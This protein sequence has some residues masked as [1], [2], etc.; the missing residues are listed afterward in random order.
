MWLVG[1]PVG[2]L[3]FS[4]HLLSPAAWDTERRSQLRLGRV[5][6]EGHRAFDS[7]KESRNGDYPVLRSRVWMESFGISLQN[8]F[9]SKAIFSKYTCMS[10]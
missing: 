3:H 7:Q 2:G 10:Q 1:P 5:Q 6:E 9:L 8:T 4:P